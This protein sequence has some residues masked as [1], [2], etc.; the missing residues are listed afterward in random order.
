M[1]DMNEQQEQVMT[2]EITITPDAA[3]EIRRIRTENQIP[4]SHALRMGVKSGGCCGISYLLAFDE[5]ADETD[6]IFQSEEIRIFIDDQSLIHLSG[7]TLEYVDGPH[8]KGFRF[9][10]PNDA[11]SCN[12]EDGCCE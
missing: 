12:C 6:K 10:N 11:K 5:K 9:N 3:K 7:T 4:D 2:Q 8:G 1:A